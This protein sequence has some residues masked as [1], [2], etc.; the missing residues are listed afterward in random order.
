MDVRCCCTPNKLLGT[1]PVPDTTKV[2]GRVNFVVM[3]PRNSDFRVT[4]VSPTPDYIEFEVQEWS[5]IERD[6]TVPDHELTL[7]SGHGFTRESG[8]ALK[9]EG[10]TVDTL[11]RIPGF[12]EAGAP[13]L[14]SLTKKEKP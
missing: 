13:T 10:V 12:I 5:Q 9:H 7:F 11:R 2:G 4:R 8:V 1:L 3:K 14:A 6:Q